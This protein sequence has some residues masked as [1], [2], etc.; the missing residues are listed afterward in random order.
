[1]SSAK[2]KRSNK[3]IYWL[4]GVLLVLVVVAIIKNKGKDKGEKVSTEKV[5]K[6]TIKESVGASGRIFPETEVKISSDVSGEI[7]ELTVEEGDSVVKGQ[8]LC[9]INPDTY[10]SQV[11]RGNASVNSARSQVSNAKSN[12]ESIRAQ[13][14]QTDAQLKNAKDILNRNSKLFKDGVISQQELEASQTSVRQLE[15]NLKA[16]MANIRASEE[17]ARGAEFSVKSAQAGL[18]ELQTSLRRTAI[19]APVGGIVSKLNAKKGERV[20][21]TIQMTGTEIMRIAN[22]NSM[23]VQVEVSENDIPRVVIGNEVDIELDAYVDRIFKGTVTKIANSASNLPDA[24]SL[25]ASLSS[26]KVTNFIVKIR[27][28]PASYADLIAAKKKHPF[29]PGMTASVDINTS[30]AENVLCVPIQAVTTRDLEEEKDKSEDAREKKK[31]F[32]KKIKE[33]VFVCVGDTVRQTEVKTAI[34][35][36]DYIQILSGVTEGDEVVVGPYAT[37]S[38]K[39]KSGMKFSRITEAD[40]KKEKDKKKD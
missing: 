22:M 27:V 34:Q 8:L 38:R 7:I 28:D 37:V 11:E 35:D 15:A 31:D 26:D 36:N 6:R 18:K 9:R 30:I 16:A 17:S 25:G 12:I 24:S 19:Y 5:Q 1:M 4:A 29:R 10:E 20:V 33:I 32:S 40:K 13:K 21:G 3:L 14:E 2:P 23:E 39:L